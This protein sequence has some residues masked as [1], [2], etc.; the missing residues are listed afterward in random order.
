MYCEIDHNRLCLRIA[1]QYVSV[2]AV[3]FDGYEFLV[4]R[5]YSS[6]RSY[7]LLTET[8][9]GHLPHMINDVFMATTYTYL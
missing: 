1:A 2:L 3:N 5:S 4:T 6:H 7:A 8:R 9:V